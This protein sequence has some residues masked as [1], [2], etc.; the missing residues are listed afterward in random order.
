[1]LYKKKTF[2]MLNIHNQILDLD[3]I[4]ITCSGFIFNILT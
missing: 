2:E 1:M 4:P 3:C